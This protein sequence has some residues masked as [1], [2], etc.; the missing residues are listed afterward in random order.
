MKKALKLDNIIKDEI[1]YIMDYSD[2][3]TETKNNITA[4]ILPLIID[5]LKA[6]AKKDPAA[7]GSCEYIWKSYTTFKA[8]MYYRIANAIY[9]Y[10]TLK[11]EVLKEIARQI[12]EKAKVMTGV[13]IHPGAKIG[14]RF[15]C[16]HG[17]GTVIGETS[18]IGDDCYMLQGV[19]LGVS[20][21]GIKVISG[22]RHPTIGNNVRIGGHAKI[23]GP[24]KIGNNC[25]I[26]PQVVITEDVPD[27]SKVI[28]VNQYQLL[29]P[30]QEIE[31]YGITPLTKKWLILH[32]KGLKNSS[33]CLIVN[34]TYLHDLKIIH[35][36]NQHIVFTIKK[37]QTGNSISIAVKDKNNHIVALIKESFALKKF[38]ER[39]LIYQENKRLSYN[40]FKGFNPEISLI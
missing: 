10:Q 13:E 25:E 35:Q 40:L 1:Y 14:A 9:Y 8:V 22:K 29:K 6:F 31:L 26:S 12:S 37:N 38:L 11:K 20:N 2:I 27:N 23:L 39:P 21:F 32:G 16:D 15:I 4:L 7:Q 24:I 18:V 3:N 19:I 17:T 33:I 34:N 36:S 30:K 5:D 28:I